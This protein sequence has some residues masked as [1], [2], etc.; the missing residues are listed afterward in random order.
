MLA[1][2]PDTHSFKLK[3]SN[4]CKSNLGS[5]PDWNSVFSHSTVKPLPRAEALSLLIIHPPPLEPGLEL[6]PEHRRGS[7]ERK[8][9]CCYQKRRKGDEEEKRKGGKAAGHQQ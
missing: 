6:Y 8:S 9:G 3:S 1:A 4:S 2:A 5:H 7:S